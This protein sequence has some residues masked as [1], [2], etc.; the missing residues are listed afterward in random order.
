[1]PILLEIF[2]FVIL[3]DFLY[4]VYTYAMIV[5][6]RA[7]QPLPQLLVEQF[8]TLLSQCRYTG[9]SRAVDNVSG[10]RYVSD[11]RS[12]GHKI[13]YRPGHLLSWWRLIMK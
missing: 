1:M 12:R 7:K 10:C 2:P 5:H 8:D 4:R 11:C 3:N 9:P 6:T 13:D